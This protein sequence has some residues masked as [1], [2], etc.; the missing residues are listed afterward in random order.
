MQIDTHRGAPPLYLQV[1]N[2]LKRKIEEG[3]YPRGSLIPPEP[4]L[5]KMFHVS[6][7][8]IR[9][10]I[11]E[12]VTEGYVNKKRGKGTSVT[13]SDKIN[14]NASAIRS[15]TTELEQRGITPGTSHVSI[16]LISASKEIRDLLELAPKEKVYCLVRIRTANKTPVVL[17]KTYIP[18]RYDLSLNAADYM[19]SMYSLFDQR[20]IGRPVTIK[21][22][23]SAMSSSK[24]IARALEILEQEPVLKRVRLAYDEHNQPIEYTISYYNGARYEYSIELHDR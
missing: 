17:F 9:Q 13:Y 7:I 23:F 4:Q 10:A 18:G 19:G 5:E 15:F 6:R 2:D 1:K 20:G 12:L 3:F 24:E 16:E 21:E 11:S 22:T 14:E 8:T